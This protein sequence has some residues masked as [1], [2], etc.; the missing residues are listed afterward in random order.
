MQ[1]KFQSSQPV[2]QIV[3][4]Y[5]GAAMLFKRYNIDFC[6]GGGK[7]LAEALADRGISEQGFVGELHEAYQAYLNR[8][9]LELDWREEPLGALADHIVTA[10]HQYLR[11]ALPAL[12]GFVAKVDRVHGDRHPELRLVNESFH[13]LK[14]ELEEHMAAEEALL[15]PVIRTYEE[16]GARADLDRA[17]QTLAELEAEHAEAG[18]IL[19]SIR[20]ATGDYRLPPDACRTYMV[21]YH[22]LAELESDMFMHIHLE[23]NILFARL[24]QAAG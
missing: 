8:G 9:A 21:T 14:Q 15:F 19:A 12:S 13:R 5:P 1:M 24:R 2:G 6:C 11:Q 4:A 18:G 23:N 20:Q 3:A 16:T 17:L 10:H 22:E 7:P